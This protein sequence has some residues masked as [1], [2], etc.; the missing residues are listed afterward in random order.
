MEKR[1]NYLVSEP[2]NHATKFFTKNLLD[3]EMR[4]NQS[5][6]NK[7]VC[8]GLLI[9]NLSKTILY[10]LLYNYVKPKYNKKRK[11][12]YGYSQSHCPFKNR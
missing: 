8:F 3:M 10:D 2:N 6:M 1:R 4:K 11:L 9:L 12:L 5:L 7:S